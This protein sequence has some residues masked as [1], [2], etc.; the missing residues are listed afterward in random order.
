MWFRITP[1]DSGWLQM[2][3]DA[4]E[5]LRVTLDDSGQL[6]M[7]PTP[8]GTS[9]S[10]FAGIGSGRTIVEVG[11]E[12]WVCFRLQIVFF[13]REFKQFC[14]HYVNNIL[15]RAVL[16]SVSIDHYFHHGLMRS[17]HLTRSVRLYLPSPYYSIPQSPCSNCLF[18]F[19]VRRVLP[20]I[21]Q[22]KVTCW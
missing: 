16:L 20:V 17:A 8:V 12:S 21:G 6:R 3:L 14:I 7:T 10:D 22:F 2:T 11:S 15:K 9:D 4:S 18:Y 1:D 19:M 13:F 5:R